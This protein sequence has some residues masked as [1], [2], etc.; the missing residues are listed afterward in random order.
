MSK[1]FRIYTGGA[2][3]YQGWHADGNFPYNDRARK[4]I[5]DPNG[6]SA[7][8]EITSIPSPF[9]RIDLVKTAFAEVVRDKDLDGSTIF[10]KMVSDSLDVGEIFFNIDKFQQTIEIIAW[11][12]K[13]AIASLMDDGDDGHRFVADALL[14]YMASDKASYN[15]DDLRNIYLLN[16]KDGPESLNIIGATS[17]ATI[18][19][20]G[21]NDLSYVD[22]VFFANNDKPFDVEYQP[23]YKRDFEY[24][25]AWFALRHSVPG[26][27]NKFR[28]VDD[29]LEATY[30]A[31][32][33]NPRR[34]EL[35]SAKLSDFLTIDVKT[36]QQS[37]EVEVLGT[38]LPKKKPSVV[39]SEFQIK[40]D[41]SVEGTLPLVLPVEAGNKY[42]SLQFTNGE[43]GKENKAPY[44]DDAAIENRTLPFDGTP[45]PYLTIGDLLEDTIVKVPHTLNK[46]YYF[47]GGIGLGDNAGLSYLL[48]IKPLFF[49]YF[50][51]ET[52]RNSTSDG[53]PM[54]VLDNIGGS[55]RATMRVPIEGNSSVDY[56]EY[57]RTYYET[58]SPKATENKG[59]MKKL[60]FAGLV[61]PAMRFA[62]GSDAYYTVSCVS[63]FSDK[64]DL[65]FFEGDVEVKDVLSDCRN[66]NGEF[67]FKALTYTL[68]GANFDFI[69]VSSKNVCGLLVP[70]FDEH[71]GLDSY[72][73][74][75]DLGTT[76]THIEFK[77]GRDPVAKP[78][79]YDAK[80]SL[81][82]TFFEATYKGEN[83]KDLLEEND[84]IMK[85]FL[86]FKVRKGESDF[87][88]PTRTVLS[89]AKTTDWTLELRPFG[90][91][92]LNLAYNKKEDL[93]YNSPLVNIKWSNEPNAKT[94]M[95]AYIDNVM[96]L[97][98]NKIVANNGSLTDPQI[99]W[100]YPNSMSPRRV[101][102]MREAW[103]NSYEKWFHSQDGTHEVSESVAPIRYY[104]RRYASAT[105]LVSVD[106]GGGTTDIAFSSAGKADYITSFKFAA[107]TPFEDG[108]SDINTSN[109]VVDWFKQSISN[110]LN[111]NDKGELASIF[112]K[113]D[114]HTSDMASFLFSLKENSAV[115]DLNS[116]SIDF[117]K[118]LQDDD[119]FKIVFIIFYTAIVYHIAKIVKEKG[120]TPPRHF[121]FS[122]NGSK[123]VNILSSD[124][125]ILEEYTKTVFEE[126]LGEAYP[127]PLEILGLEKNSNPKEVTCKGGLIDDSGLAKSPVKLV[128]RD[129]SG[130]FVDSVDTYQ[131]ID[132]DQKKSIIDS[133]KEFFKFVLE[134]IPSKFNYDDYFGVNAESL[135]IAR[136]VCKFDL[137]TYLDKGIELS[138]KESG[139]RQNK[140][141]DALSFY[142]I[143][144]VLKAI[145]DELYKHYSA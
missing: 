123:L 47:D 7:K 88:F 36:D 95:Q 19:F 106:I 64:Y 129:S 50:K 130:R 26:F 29:Y 86:P 84:L 127:S 63:L 55:V 71:R 15:F 30:K 126:V 125:K 44:A 31:L 39:Q 136:E 43:W 137:D 12:P 132:D 24:V 27:A 58:G 69:Q 101:A 16:Y 121:A 141:E 83:Q 139:D 23:L 2:D 107:N 33:G 62:N 49:K 98:R 143:K 9:A 119:K 97:I 17:P 110:V 131:S 92:N 117:N 114:G 22:D 8:S 76:N 28:D 103:N 108:F 61:M 140:I 46:K 109:G 5:K 53:K 124:K 93:E 99:T 102:Q 113:V 142:P 42:A 45:H 21:A 100:L 75:V 38:N 145:S 116:M 74:A 59:G 35:D 91:V 3:T 57:Q 6:A 20:S 90:L 111:G 25:K 138:V 133:V 115:K 10:H 89:S 41:R 13:T 85:D 135:S 40:P 118:M 18:F 14:K 48:P 73:F 32:K 144:G 79:E 87:S 4:T 94:A 82:G 134:T 120:L 37:N 60:D 51:P 54:F 122:G 80:E 66:A 104:F 112:A 65:R 68:K 11:D 52:L 34:S 128:L 105:N 56:V 67:G 96:L 81:L 78:F 77:V 1:V 70:R 72:S